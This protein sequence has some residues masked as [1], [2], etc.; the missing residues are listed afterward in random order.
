MIHAFEKIKKMR[1]DLKDEI[2]KLGKENL[3]TV[4]NALFDKFPE[5]DG[6]VWDQYTP[7]FNDGEPC[8][9]SVN[10]LRICS[11]AITTAFP[12]ISDYGNDEMYA[13]SIQ[14]AVQKDGVS[15]ATRERYMSIVK[16]AKEI[17]TIAQQNEDIWEDVFGDHVK[18]SFGRGDTT[19]T[20][21]ECD[22]D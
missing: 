3:I 7:Y 15:A 4:Y 14:Y 5:I 11:S 13:Y 19:F 22:H 18:V 16:E 10:E 20:I 6:V 9:F 8:Y 2:Q 21:V 12:D 1:K 17:S